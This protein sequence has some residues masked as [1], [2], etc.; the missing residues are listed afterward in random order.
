MKVQFILQFGQTYLSIPRRA[1]NTHKELQ[2]ALSLLKNK[3]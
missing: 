2:Q 3:G 1:F